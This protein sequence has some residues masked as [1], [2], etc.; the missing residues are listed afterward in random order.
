MDVTS[1]EW[2]GKRFQKYLLE[3]TEKPGVYEIH[4]DLELK[5]LAVGNKLQHIVDGIKIKKYKVL[6]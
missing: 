3:I 4:R 2:N 5:P 6:H 1:Y